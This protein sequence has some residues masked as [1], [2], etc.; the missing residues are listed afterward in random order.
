MNTQK[1]LYLRGHSGKHPFP[2]PHPTHS[3]VLLLSQ[4]LL[5]LPCKPH[6][7]LVNLTLKDYPLILKIREDSLYSQA[8]P[9]SLY[10]SA[11]LSVLLDLRWGS[12]HS[13]AWRASLGI[14]F[15]KVSG[16]DFLTF[17][18]F[19]SFHSLFSNLTILICCLCVFGD[20]GGGE[21]Q[22]SQEVR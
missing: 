3:F 21:P 16:L 10:C 9:D 6:S 22:Q 15:F 13:F 12:S 7:A 5:P 2:L 1:V 11:I 8:L 17:H 4:I 20:L 14:L 18:L 19:K